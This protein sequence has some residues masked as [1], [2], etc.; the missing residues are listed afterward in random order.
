MSMRGDTF[1][2]KPY[3]ATIRDKHEMLCL[4]S[5]KRLLLQW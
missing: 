1:E 2:Q 4:L 5:L 3:G